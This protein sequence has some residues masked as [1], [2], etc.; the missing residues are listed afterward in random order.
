MNESKRRARSRFWASQSG[1]AA[2]PKS[3]VVRISVKESGTVD[4]AIR[5][6]RTSRLTEFPS[7]SMVLKDD[8]QTQ[9]SDK[10]NT[11]EINL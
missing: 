1:L 9:L 6:S 10:R 8:E 11:Y 2:M 3:S 4:V 5:V 7:L